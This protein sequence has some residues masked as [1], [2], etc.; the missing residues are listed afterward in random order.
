MNVWRFND[1]PFLLESYSNDYIGFVYM[2]ANNKTNKYYIGQ[3]RFYRTI[4]RPPLKGKKR[5]RK[6][7]VESDWK[8]YC[9]SSKSLSKDINEGNI[10]DFTREILFLCETKSSMNYVE[11]LYQIYSGSIFDKNC[12]NGIVN[13][14]IGKSAIM[15]RE[16]E[17]E[18]I[19]K[20]QILMKG[21]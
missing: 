7:V 6:E 15:A 14:R 2:I 10:E 12:Y 9:G 13:V 17:V 21:L 19:Q 4:V 18:R 11:L 8:T 3:K 1:E 16:S 5:K 20:L